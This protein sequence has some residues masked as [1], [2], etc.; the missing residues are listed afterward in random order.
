MVSLNNS[1]SNKKLTMSMV[2]DVLFNEKIRRREM[3]TTD[4]SESQ[5]LVL[6]GSRERGRGQGRCHHKGTGRG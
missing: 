5:A 2:M 6:E 4:Q 1:A 3:G